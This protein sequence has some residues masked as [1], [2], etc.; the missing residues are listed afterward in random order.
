MRLDV[1]DVDADFRLLVLVL[2]FLFSRRRLLMLER[3]RD[4]VEVIG[5]DSGSRGACS[6][7]LGLIAQR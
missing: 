4:V 6:L 7:G 5:S 2:V 1:V 3:K